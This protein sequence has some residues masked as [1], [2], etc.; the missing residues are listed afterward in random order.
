MTMRMTMRSARRRAAAPSCVSVVVPDGCSAGDLLT[1]STAHATFNV[2]VPDGCCAGTSFDVAFEEAPSPPTH[3]VVVPEGC[4]AGDTMNVELDGQVFHVIVPNGFCAGDVL[5]C[6]L[7]DDSET[8]MSSEHEQPREQQHAP[9]SP[10]ASA[11]PAWPAHGLH[12]A[13]E[14][15]ELLRSDGSYSLGTVV[16]AYDGPYESPLY[17]VRMDNG[18]FK[19]AVAED[20]CFRVSLSTSYEPTDDQARTLVQWQMSQMMGHDD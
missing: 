14:R 10:T 5:P 16:G 2:A 17:Q 1:V 4:F 20:E 11:A 8:L 3:E 13:G 6:N 12:S 7:L 15:V 9:E 19:H 18:V